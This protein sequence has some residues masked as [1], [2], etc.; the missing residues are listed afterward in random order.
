MRL[1]TGQVINNRYRIVKLLGQGGFGAVY[2]AWDTNL[3]IAV[4]LKENLDTTPEAQRQF[5]REATVLWGLSHP[6]LPRVS[7]HFTIA[8]RGQYLVM[9]LIEGDDLETIIAREGRINEQ[10]AVAW[11]GQIADA[12][13]YLHTQPEPVIHR[14]IKPANIRITPAGKAYLVDFGLVKL[15]EQHQ[16]TTM[17][18]RAVT[19][20]YSPP[21]QYGQGDTNAQSDIYALAATLYNALTGIDPV[22]SVRRWVSGVELQP[23]R[24]LNSTVSAHIA[25]AIEKAMDMSPTQ[26]F[27]TARQFNLSLHNRAVTD[28]TVVIDYSDVPG[29]AAP[30]QNRRGRSFAYSLI[31]LIA[32]VGIVGVIWT[33]TDILP[34]STVIA[35]VT[36]TVDF[37]ETQSTEIA[38]TETRQQVE[39]AETD[40][41]I[42][43]T[44]TRSAEIAQLTEAAIIAAA[45]DTPTPQTPTSTTPPDTPTVPP[46]TATTPPPAP[47]ITPIPTT[48]PTVNGKIAFD[49][50]RDNGRG[51]TTDI[52]IMDA[53]GSNVRRLTSNS[54]QE[55]EAEFSPDG[56]WIAYER[57]NSNGNW[58]IYAM[59]IDGSSNQFLVEGRNPA[60]SPD[61]AYIAYATI[62]FDIWLYEISTGNT[63]K[64]T[65]GWEDRAP[66]WSPDGTEL[67]IMS[68]LSGVW[69]I[70][71]VNVV[72]S[73]R[74]QLTVGAVNSRFPVWSP[75]GTLIAYNTL[76]GSG[77][78]DDIWVIEPSAENNRQLTT[79]GNNGR[80]T[81]SPDSQLLL[82]NRYEATR[83]DWLIYQM[84]RDGGNALRL[85]TAGDDQRAT[86]SNRP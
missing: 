56:Q 60:W 78:P 51:A 66:N 61:G 54:V 63:W 27:A 55:D 52:Y 24:Y 68:K 7:D 71:V 17:G 10:Q 20:G 73:E 26:R 18:A 6:N 49:S 59:R 69:Q 29:S 8:G 23:V 53:D 13:T 16:K 57:K 1:D 5:S 39:V 64:V 41:A 58:D 79:D 15:Y 62:Q 47:T 14:D 86:W 48:P 67:V 33:T 76:T 82:F 81:W 77:W 72:T 46:P 83:E 12:L 85:T 28:P 31:G 19:P 34:F 75:D 50:T 22:E 32:L 9:E 30:V 2:R 84:D 44:E 37:A 65:N 4:A 3:N 80:P 25:N 38:L 45:T 40:E 35:E 43:L 70:V 42:I 36:N 74:R 11:I 21:E